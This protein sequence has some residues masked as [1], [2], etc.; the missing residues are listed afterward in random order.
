MNRP[1]SFRF[2]LAAITV[3]TSGF[4]LIAF[5]AVSGWIL[6]QDR[7]R[8]LDRE[9]Q[10]FGCRV[11]GRAGRNVD[12]QQ[13]RFSLADRIGEERAARRFICL[14]DRSGPILY[15]DANWP[16]AIPP[17][18]YLPGT[19]LMDPQPNVQDVRPRDEG[20][21][22]PVR[23]QYQPR[24]YTERQ[25][26]AHARVA[27][28]GNKE[29][30]AVIGADLRPIDADLRSLG[31]SF[32]AALPGAL[33]VVALGA[34]VVARKALAP[35][36]ALSARMETL[37][38]RGLD[39]RIEIERADAE[40]RRIIRAFNAMME[41]LERSFHQAN[42]FTADASHEL[43]TPLAVMQGALERAVARP[44]SGPE[45]QQAFSELLDEVVRQ[46]RVLDGLL[47]LSRADAGQLPVHREDVALSEMLQSLLD[48]AELH[49]EPRGIAIRRQ[50]GPDVHLSA[51]PTLLR[52]AV[53]NLLSNAVKHNQDGGWI[54]CQL[55]GGEGRAELIITNTGDPIPV[56]ERE[57]VFQRF[58]R[59]GR[60]TAR[61]PDG[62]GLGLALAQEIALAHGGTLVLEGSAGNAATVSFRL[63]LPLGAGPP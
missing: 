26:G 35:I 45:A 57:A 19:Q 17:E 52:R 36:D 11:A 41:R 33:V 37:S 60:A 15:R 3:A 42:R 38:A 6:Y 50:I 22:P 43:R 21:Q 40:F 10:D 47:L 2:R 1:R 51:D 62:V 4:V 34:L 23:M 49:A 27:A 18:K 14:I 53:E 56:S 46:R 48:D 59:G 20:K 25:D 30:I 24:F 63:R 32:A 13:I 16:A 7:L 58:Y 9:L 61:A 12:G 44:P 55:S 29:V 28:F 5:G 39:Q 8:T 31:V 54:E